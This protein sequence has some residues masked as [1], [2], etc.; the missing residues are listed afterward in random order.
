M[1]NLL[2][3]EYK[4]R[5]KAQKKWNG[6]LS[7]AI[8]ILFLCVFAMVGMVGIKMYFEVENRYQANILESYKEYTTTIG[9]NF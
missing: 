7:L 9:I 2:P 4:N 5:I 3:E 8:N 1:I 6:F